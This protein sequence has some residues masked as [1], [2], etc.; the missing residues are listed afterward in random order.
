MYVLQ[1]LVKSSSMV[2]FH[3]QPLYSGHC[4]FVTQ[5]LPHIK[6]LVSST[7]VMSCIMLVVSL[8][9]TKQQ[10][11]KDWFHHPSSVVYS[12]YCFFLTHKLHKLRNRKGLVS[13]ILIL[14]C[15]MSGLWCIMTMTVVS[16]LLTN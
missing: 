11:K 15:I 13:T 10:T 1:H 9:L 6:R 14:W 7:L 2:G 16:L 3:H 4:L 12:G 8:S 5:K